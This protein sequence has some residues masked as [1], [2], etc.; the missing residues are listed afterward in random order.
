M[1]S[2]CPR[3]HQHLG[4]LSRNAQA[5]QHQALKVVGLLDAL[6]PAHKGKKGVW[7]TVRSS[8][9]LPTRKG[10]QGARLTAEAAFEAL[11][12]DPAKQLAHY[13]TDLQRTCSSMFLGASSPTPH[14][15]SHPLLE[16]FRGPWMHCD[17]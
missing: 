15:M 12:P 9:F 14:I 3:G 4:L 11:P 7:L 17:L 16:H 5:A 2:A 10:K 6:L 8:F 1:A 13:A